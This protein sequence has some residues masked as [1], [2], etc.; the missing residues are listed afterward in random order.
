MNGQD[1]ITIGW[2]EWVALPD[3]DL[4]AVK[5][6]IDTGARTSAIHAFDIRLLD[7]DND[8]VP[9]VEFKVQ[10]LQRNDTLV[11]SCRAPLVDRRRVTDSGGHAEERFVVSTRLVLGEASHTMEMTL[12]ERPNMLFRMLLGRTA[13]RGSFLVDPGVSFTCGRPPARRLYD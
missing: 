6:K 11:R 5:A 13:L 12:T 9:M 8:A 2:R 4:P 10:P 7:S 1:L 3:L